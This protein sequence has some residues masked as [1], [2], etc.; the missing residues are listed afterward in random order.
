MTAIKDP[1]PKPGDNNNMATLEHID[2]ECK[3]KCWFIS[4]SLEG[5]VL[6]VPVMQA[7]FPTLTD[8]DLSLTVKSGVGRRWFVFG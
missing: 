7:P 3:I 2:R 1:H 6:L 8:L 5:K 4:S